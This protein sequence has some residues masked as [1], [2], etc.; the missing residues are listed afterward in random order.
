MFWCKG[1]GIWGKRKGDKNK[2]TSEKDQLM[3]RRGKT[4]RVWVVHKKREGGDSH[5]I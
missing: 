4:D 5:P 1:E 2:K 3:A